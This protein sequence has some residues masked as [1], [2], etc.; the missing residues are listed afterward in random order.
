MAKGVITP[1]TRLMFLQRM[2]ART[3]TVRRRQ[4][5]LF[6]IFWN[7]SVTESEVV[8]TPGCRTAADSFA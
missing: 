1:A 2:S 4:L 6:G 5:S 8:E 3:G 7:H